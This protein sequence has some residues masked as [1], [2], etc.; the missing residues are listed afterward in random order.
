MEIS[1]TTKHVLTFEVKEYIGTEGG[2]DEE[3]FGN[4]T[5][6]IKEAINNI[7]LA[8]SKFPK[9]NWIIECRVETIIS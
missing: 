2:M 9:A 5:F 3:T 6:D 7:E 1:K 8:R 4:V